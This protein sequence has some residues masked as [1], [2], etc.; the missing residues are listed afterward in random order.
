MLNRIKVGSLLSVLT[1]VHVCCMA[2]LVL[3]Y[4]PNPD[5]SLVT[6]MNTSAMVT[7]IYLCCFNPLLDGGIPK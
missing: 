7:A 2:T 4:P 1:N 6:T 3:P 5:A